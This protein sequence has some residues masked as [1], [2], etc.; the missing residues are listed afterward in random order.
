M[1][2]KPPDADLSA[3]DLERKIARWRERIRGNAVRGRSLLPDPEE[4]ARDSRRMQR[5]YLDC[6]TTAGFTSHFWPVVEPDRR[7]VPGWHL[8]C[9]GEHLDEVSR[10]GGSIQNLII[11]VPPRTMKGCAFDTPVLTPTG[12]RKHGE[13]NPGDEVFGPDGRA[14]R[15]VAKS[16]P[17]ACDRLVRLSNGDEVKVNGDHLW[18][19][20]SRSMQK[21]VT[22]TT[23]R[24]SGLVLH[25]GGRCTFQLPAAAAAEM[26]ERSDLTLHPYFLGCWLGDGT[27]DKP[28]ITHDADDDAHL[29]AIEER[30]GLRVTIKHTHPDPESRSVR[31]EFRR[32]GVVENLRREGLYGNKHIPEKYLRA[33]A[34]QRMQLLAG[35]IDTDGC[36]T[37]DGRVKIGTSSERLR[38]DVVDLCTTLGLRPAVV[39]YVTPAW[40]EYDAKRP[41]WVVCFQPTG[42]IPCAIE[43]KRPTRFSPQRRV[44][45]ESIT[46]AEPEVG[47]CIT[48]DRED[49]LYL[50]GRTAQPTHNS[51][52]TCVF[53]FCKTWTHRPGTRWMFASFGSDLV[54]RDS[55]RC[56]EIIDTPLYSR[57]WDVSI[58]GK[59][60]T[61]MR[62]TNT[63]QGFRYSVTVNGQGMG[64]GADFLCH[65]AGTPITTARGLVAVED[66]RP[67][68]RVLA[69]DHAAGVTC[70]RPVT[71]NFKR[72]GEGA[73]SDVYGRRDLL[74]RVRTRA[75]RELVLTGNHPVWVGGRGY[76]PAAELSAGDEVS[77]LEDADV[78]P[79]PAGVRHPHP[80]VKAEAAPAP[81]LWPGLPRGVERDGSE[82]GQPGT[83]FPVRGVREGVPLAIPFGRPGGAHLLAGVSGGAAVGG[84]L[85][86]DRHPV[87]EL[88]GQPVA[89]AEPGAGRPQG[90]LLAGV[91]RGAAPGG[92]AGKK[93]RAV[94]VGGVGGPLPGGVLRVA[95]AAGAGPG[96]G[97]RGVPHEPGGTQG[98]ARGRPER[99]P[100]R[101]GRDEQ[102]AGESGGGLQGVSRE[103][104]RLADQSGG[105]GGE[106]PGVLA[107][108]VESV[109]L[110]GERHTVYSIEV[111]EH[112][113]YFAAGVLV[114]NCIDDPQ[115]PKR[116]A[117]AIER[118][119]T[120]RW[121]RATFS[122]RVNDELTGRKVVIMQRLNERDLTGYLVA[123]QTG[124]E[125]LVLPMRYEPR[126]YWYGHGMGPPPG[127]CPDEGDGAVVLLGQPVEAPRTPSP[128]AGT[129]DAFALPVPEAE[130][131]PA[132]TRRDDLVSTFL[133]ALGA[134]RHADPTGE[135]DQ[136]APAE[137]LAAG[138]NVERLAG[139]VGDGQ[140]DEPEAA[141]EEAKAPRD[142]IRPTSLQLKFPRLLDG[143]A[144]SGRC[145]EGD[146]LWPERFPEAA[147][148]KAEREL[149]PEAPGQYAQRPTG[150]GGDIFQAD[151][152]RRFEPV[153]EA[154]VDPRTGVERQYFGRVRLFGP[155][156]SQRR[157]FRAEHVL[158]FQTIDT[159]L[160]EGRRSAYTAVVT[161]GVTPEYDLIL[162]HSF[163]GRLNVQYQ[164]P[165]VKALKRGPVHWHQ[166]RHQ[167]T[168]AGRWPFRV[169]VQ[170]IENK[171]SGVGIIQEAAA[172]GNPLHPMKADKDK[173]TRAVP[174]AGMYLA[175]KVYHP[176]EGPRWLA[177]VEAEL[178]Q[179]PN[180]A[181]KDIADCVGHAGLLVTQDK[182]IRG[183]VAK[184]V[185]AEVPP[186]EAGDDR[187]TVIETTA[188]GHEILWPDDEAP[189]KTPPGFG[190]Y[191]DII[192]GLFP[193][194]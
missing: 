93:E 88:R 159:A 153:W 92:G 165:L 14:V 9:V 91:R 135:G 130:R 28:A 17:F 127:M 5:F 116:A 115:N 47:N 71:H 100:H 83:G 136:P 39:E 145:R 22:Y 178:L 33:S 30:C 77:A 180:G 105:V 90:V 101:L 45:I 121:Y 107:D 61:Q 168:P 109:T 72:V 123:E 170:A 68:D 7:F 32:Q 89:A 4:L 40:G 166:R 114:H 75:G 125:Q 46:A 149:G 35:L 18:T 81:L 80:A 70:W 113:N 167:I 37:G 182:L 8:G 185:M 141:P 38:D 85:R 13:L 147:V 156:P 110:L 140:A 151:H 131:P 94:P 41:H 118:E 189:M 161:W 54:Q 132:Q 124:W 31:S 48:V 106:T 50:V 152:F 148:A 177:D 164:Y 87:H 52:L 6:E 137:D 188:G 187:T 169:G 82:P 43:R 96:R 158:W 76:V 65:P 20:Y 102:R 128:D 2:T 190:Q 25:S 142:H 59:Q 64:E 122:R 117:S 191:R 23:D 86:E 160:T 186:G 16:A 179:F 55:M 36:V 26:P 62:Y 3:A 29:K 184:R 12:W 120:I 67:G 171:A 19:V 103:D 15:V 193:A 79:L 139:P 175:G 181:Y 157:E 194:E 112:H 34:A 183:L 133:K 176:R 173:V 78:R 154:D 138:A 97:L 155:D 57:L 174:V 98:P 53:W 104:A 163:R 42:P 63:H 21:W 162:W 99:P 51:L 129:P 84:Q 10:V 108:A 143:P 56:R 1:T 146:L 134:E 24:L 144:G 11:N 74:Y 73:D 150:E 111:A 44:G 69:F 172:D 49:G 66:V 119:N 192:N 27:A 126:R 95:E 58:K 60:D